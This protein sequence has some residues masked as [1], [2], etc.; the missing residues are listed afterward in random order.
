MAVPTASPQIEGAWNLDGKSPSIWDTFV[1]D[2]HADH[3]L[4]GAT[5]DVAND[6]YHKY[7]EDLPL[8]KNV[9]G[10]TTYDFTIAWS[11][12]MPAGRGPL[13]PKGV[14]FYRNVIRTSNAFG[15]SNICVSVPLIYK[16]GNL[17]INAKIFATDAL[18]LGLA[19]IAADGI[20]RVNS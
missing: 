17:L 13:N 1:H 16:A 11:R 19:A 20:W 4:Y 2:K 9:L 18:S 14:A 10:V 8:F 7:T 6:F 3:I 15:M 12:I 5:G